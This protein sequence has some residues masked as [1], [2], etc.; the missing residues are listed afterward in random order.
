MA[1]AASDTL[2]NQLDAP[3]NQHTRSK[4]HKKSDSTYTDHRFDDSLSAG[5]SDFEE[6]SHNICLDPTVGFEL[7]Q[8]EPRNQLGGPDLDREAFTRRDGERLGEIEH[9]S[10]LTRP[11]GG[12]RRHPS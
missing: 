12:G 7:P 1:L 8:M 4:D 2:Q 5:R 3:G 10:P 11:R 6:R 9:T